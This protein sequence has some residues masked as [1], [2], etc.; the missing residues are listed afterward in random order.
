MVEVIRPF[1]WHQTFDPKGLSA[2]VPGLYT[3]QPKKK[4]LF[5]AEHPLREFFFFTE[6]NK[7]ELFR[8]GFSPR[9]FAE[10]LCE[11]SRRYS[12]KFRDG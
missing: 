4:A 2:P 12:A 7:T 1:C 9:N 10:K 8:R 5:A 3:D 6:K 11:I